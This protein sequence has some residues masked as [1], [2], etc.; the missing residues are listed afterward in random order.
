MHNTS[1]ALE[2]LT[3]QQFAAR[4]GNAPAGGTS[5][6]QP[7]QS[8]PVAPV[9]TTP[10]AS[11]PVASPQPQTLSAEQFQAKYGTPAAPEKKYGDYT[12][13]EIDAKFPA[14][15]T[16]DP[17]GI[18][19]GF[20]GK[21]FTGN[22][23]KFGKTAGEAFA[24]PKNAELYDQAMQTY[25]TVQT[26]L[27]KAIKAKKDA[28]QDY[29]RLQNAL[30]E[31][32][33]DVPKIEDFTGDVINKT[34]EQVLGEAAGTVLE[35]TAGGGLESGVENATSKT[36]STGQKLFK[37]AKIG[38]AY[39]GIGGASEALQNNEGVGDVAKDTAIGT[40]LGAGTGA[41]LE[42]V[43]S[44]IS[45]IPFL[46]GKQ[47]AIDHYV[48]I[49]KENFAKPTTLPQESSYKGAN[50]IFNNAKK[51]GTDLAEEAVN[52]GIRHDSIIEG[53]K[54]NTKDTAENLRKDAMQASHDTVRPALAAAEGG[55]QRVPITDIRDNVIKQIKDIPNS[56]VTDADR[57]K[58]ISRAKTK[59]GPDSAA[60]IAH[61]DGYTLT[62][63]HDNKIVADQNG[64]Y[65]PLGNHADNILA[66]QSR[67]EGNVFRKLVEDKA[68]SE[69]DIKGLNAQIAKKFQLANYLDALH[70]KKVPKGIVEKAVD[71]LGKIAGAKLGYQFGGGILPGAIGYHVGGVL[72]DTFQ[73]LSNPAKGYYLD[74]LEKTES[75]LFKE[76]QDYI[77]KEEVERLTRKKLPAGKIFTGTPDVINL[78]SEGILEGQAKIKK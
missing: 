36:L 69:L 19:G 37:G 17:D 10:D 53:G 29:S 31:H 7:A 45:K 56:Q 51:Q 12:Q 38:A 58:M 65:K 46:K 41:A 68:P 11:A 55:V 5:T 14:P 28:G 27:L 1:M 43:G 59:Y 52:N 18:K 21:L 2:T 60:A 20:I 66:Q 39:G 57:E 42:G 62:D 32:S 72:L 15:G 26:N 13:A 50:I 76:F 67:T 9:A 73:H 78:P 63:L 47:G 40:A 49:E 16:P 77:G 23:Q 22:T 70:T 25:N 24:A 75:P 6:A 4:Y 34:A 74:M 71:A 64:K 35:A 54:Y 44:A 3:P 30:D 61:P 48:N 8:A 33:Q